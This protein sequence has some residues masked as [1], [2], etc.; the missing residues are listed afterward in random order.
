MEPV[1]ELKK[2]ADARWKCA[3]RFIKKHENELRREALAKKLAN[4]TNCKFWKEIKTINN[5]L[6]V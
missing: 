5:S 2:K 6:L 4:Y 3:I 1:F